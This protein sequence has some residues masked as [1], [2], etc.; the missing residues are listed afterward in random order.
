M[1]KNKISTK[2]HMSGKKYRYLTDIKARQSCIFISIE[3]FLHLALHIATQAG[4]I[5]TVRVLL[6]ESRINAESVNAK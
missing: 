3:I 4:N 6:T 2:C 5:N 1:T